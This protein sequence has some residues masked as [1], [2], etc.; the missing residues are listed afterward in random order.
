LFGEPFERTHPL[1]EKSGPE[2]KVFG[3]ISGEGQFGEHHEI[4]TVARSL[5]DRFAAPVQV[6]VEIADRGV[7]LGE[8]DAELFHGKK[9]YVPA[10]MCTT[11]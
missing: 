10:V 1:P 11:T 3:W 8:C 9:I 2:Q 7:D 6:S 4:S 5:F